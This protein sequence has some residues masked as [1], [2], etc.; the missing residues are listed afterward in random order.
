MRKENVDADDQKNNQ[1][2]IDYKDIFDRF[3]YDVPPT[4]EYLND[5]FDEII[6]YQ[7]EYGIVIQH[8][9]LVEHFAIWRNN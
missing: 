4:N 3:Y 8:A 5:D 1:G 9:D 6:R 2:G 7:A